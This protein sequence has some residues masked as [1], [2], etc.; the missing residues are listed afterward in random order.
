MPDIDTTTPAGGILSGLML[1]YQLKQHRDQLEADEAVRRAAA[2]DRERNFGLQKQKLELERQQEERLAQSATQLADYRGK[3][4]GIAEGNLEARK[5]ALADA[6]TRY[7]GL[8]DQ[9]ERRLFNQ[10]MEARIKDIHFQEQYGQD[11]EEAFIQTMNLFNAMRGPEGVGLFG[12]EP[13]AVP[14]TP[15]SAPAA[16]FRS[17]I[18]APDLRERVRGN[19]YGLRDGPLPLLSDRMN[20]I[21]VETQLMQQ[22]KR[23][24]DELFPDRQLALKLRNAATRLGMDYTKTKIEFQKILND[25]TPEEMKA[26]LEL[27]ETRIA[28]LATDRQKTLL[29]ITAMQKLW[30]MAKKDG[31]IYLTKGGTLQVK[32]GK[33]GDILGKLRSSQVNVDRLLLTT[34]STLAEVSERKGIIKTLAATE[35]NEARRMEYETELKRLEDSEEKIRA[36]A[37]NQQRDSD[38][39]NKRIFEL[40][41]ATN[42][43]EKVKPE[44]RQYDKQGRPLPQEPYRRPDA[45]EEERKNFSSPRRSRPN[46]ANEG[47][48]KRKLKPSPAGKTT[49]S[50]KMTFD[51]NGNR[52]K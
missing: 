49:T 5:R 41:Q 43:S 38:E 40:Q 30:D 6:L 15:P 37:D 18:P 47:Q 14:G 52:V 2:I 24:L 1:A 9:R 17:S 23:H 28:D 19:K 35:K 46:R 51:I 16:E 13:A 27:T 44:P 48:P 29:E 8:K 33:G 34:F 32:P 31:S 39:I 3:R 11:R 21:E 42:R 7:E 26:R 22:R 12:P 4:I 50:K 45:K 36:M 20:K 25:L 10:M